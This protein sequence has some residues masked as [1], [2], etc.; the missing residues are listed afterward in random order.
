MN[1]D[2][3]VPDEA[4]TDAQ[5]TSKVFFGDSALQSGQEHEKDK[6]N[7]DYA[8][9][10]YNKEVISTIGDGEMTNEGLVG[11]GDTDET[12]SLISDD[13]ADDQDKAELRDS[14]N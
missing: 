5:D 12:A 9:V 1:E 14:G 8:A 4:T 3:N 10:D 11:T 6:T 7:D 2:Q 13:N